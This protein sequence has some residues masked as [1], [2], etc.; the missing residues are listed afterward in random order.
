MLRR[1]RLTTLSKLLINEPPLQF[2]PTLAVVLGTERRAIAL[3][4]L[5]YMLGYRRLH[6][7]REGQRWVKANYAEWHADYFRCWS[8]DTIRKIFAGL[9][10]DGYVL[11]RQF[12]LEAGDATSF[13]GIDY[14][15]LEATHPATFAGWHP[16]DLATSHPADLVED[17]PAVL[18]AS[19]YSRKK[20]KKRDLL[21]QNEIAPGDVASDRKSRAERNAD[22][23]FTDER[24][25]AHIEVMCAPL[26][27]F[28]RRF[29]VEQVDAG[30]P[31][32]RD[33]LVA[34][35]ATGWNVTNLPGQ[36]DY[37]RRRKAAP[38]RPVAAGGATSAN[39]KLAAD[40]WRAAFR[41]AGMEIADGQ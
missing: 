15:K 41:M 34:W 4:Q 24:V 5:H 38:A 26:D 35:R 13:L 14:A 20:K 32:W 31:V 7:V 1:R 30:D 39:G 37:Y 10:E 17:H 12:D 21:L 16:A 6:V 3:Q 11:H 33:A 23:S 9:R 27:Q 2:L 28:Q 25:M 29:I 19:T 8:P 22:P 40:D 36:V 18:A